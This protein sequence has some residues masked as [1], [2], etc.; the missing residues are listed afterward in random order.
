[1]HLPSFFG[2]A[3]ETQI[4]K[5]L[6]RYLAAEENHAPEKECASLMKKLLRLLETKAMQLPR[7]YTATTVDVRQ[8]PTYNSTSMPP[9]EQCHVV[10]FFEQWCSC[11]MATKARRPCQV[12]WHHMG[13]LIA[14]VNG[15]IHMPSGAIFICPQGSYS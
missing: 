10:H 9:L 4:D 7:K 8:F 11:P 14:L 12:R 1:M 5:A 3:L 15:H 13:T 6:E 2:H